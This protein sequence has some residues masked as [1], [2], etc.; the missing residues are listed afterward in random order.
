MILITVLS[1]QALLGLAH[2]VFELFKL[3]IQYV[4]IVFL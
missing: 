3:I 2:I 1:E 4:I